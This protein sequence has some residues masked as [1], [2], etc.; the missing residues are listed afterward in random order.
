MVCPRVWF[1][2]FSLLKTP[3]LSGANVGAEITYQIVLTSSGSQ[4]TN[5]VVLTDTLDIW[6][7]ATAVDPSEGT[8]TIEDSDWGGSVV[9]DFGSLNIGDVIEVQGLPQILWPVHCVQNTPGAEFHPDLALEPIARIFRKGTQAQVD[10]YSAFFDNARRGDTGLGRRQTGARYIYKPRDRSSTGQHRG[11]RRE[12][13]LVR[14]LQLVQP[15]Q[16]C[17]QLGEK[18][19]ALLRKS[20]GSPRHP[21][22]PNPLPGARRRFGKPC[23]GTG[24]CRPA[25]G[26][27]Q[28]DGTLGGPGI[29]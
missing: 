24:S 25:A 5:N 19:G 1:N 6:Q 21:E 13:K 22:R 4:D 3:S 29:V 18:A 9:C 15:A 14:E 27:P 17:R 10:S 20:R 12:R 28:V 11:R 7:R 26:G 2:S 8:C 23:P 16:R